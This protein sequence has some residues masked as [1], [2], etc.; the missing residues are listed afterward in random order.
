MAE[1]N[2]EKTFFPPPSLLSD[3]YELEECRGKENGTAVGLEGRV[4]IKEVFSSLN[5]AQVEKISNR[6]IEMYSQTFFFTLKIKKKILLLL[7][8]FNYSILLSFECNKA[9]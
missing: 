5:E 9:F 6:P 8:E 7:S 3:G 1:K 2:M 4:T